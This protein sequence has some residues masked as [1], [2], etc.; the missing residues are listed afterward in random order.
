MRSVVS[1]RLKLAGEHLQAGDSMVLAG[2]FRSAISRHYYA[3]YHS[4]RA[5]VYA[6][7]KGD[8]F[9]R[10]SEL[11]RHLPAT[12]PDAPQWESRLTDARLLRN[13]ADYDPYPSGAVEWEPDA[14]QGLGK[15][16]MMSDLGGL[17]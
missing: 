2:H 13:Q 14:R 17:E 6:E 9:E 11:P 16:V 7:E 15:V 5:I 12:L 4:A 1:D 3:M 8:D 10:H